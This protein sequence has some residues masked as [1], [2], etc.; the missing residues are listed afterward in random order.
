[1]DSIS[2]CGLATTMSRAKTQQKVIAHSANHVTSSSSKTLNE[3]L[4]SELGLKRFFFVSDDFRKI[5]ISRIFFEY[6]ARIF[7]RRKNLI[8]VSLKH[9][10]F[11]LL[12]AAVR[13]LSQQECSS[14]LCL[15][16]CRFIVSTL[17]LPG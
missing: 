12:A 1:M 2:H 8:N 5:K 17:L 9:F 4:S 13:K 6:R 16:F 3:R 14:T 11:S 15:L 10:C 7:F